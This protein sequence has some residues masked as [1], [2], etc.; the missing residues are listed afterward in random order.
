[1]STI[2]AIRECF[3][4]SFKPIND[5]RLNDK[6]TG[7]GHIISQ[8]LPDD[9][10]DIPKVTKDKLICFALYTVDDSILKL[11]AQLYPLADDDP[12]TVR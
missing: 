10:L 9:L 7:H 6:W 1:M 8:F 2:N 11:T 12:R 3:F 5:I 4:F